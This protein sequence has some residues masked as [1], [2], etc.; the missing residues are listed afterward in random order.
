MNKK[1]LATTAVE[2]PSQI[3]SYSLQCSFCGSD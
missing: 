1:G 3:F 2:H